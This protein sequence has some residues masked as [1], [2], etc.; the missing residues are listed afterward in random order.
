MGE[1]DGVSS[2][3]VMGDGSRED[4][5]Q[6]MADGSRGED[7]MQQMMPP[8]PQQTPPRPQNWALR[9]ATQFTRGISRTIIVRAESDRFVLVAQPGLRT[10]TTIP[11][12]D[13]VAS[14]ADQLVQAIWEF[15]EAWGIAGRDVHWRPILQVRVTP[16]GERRL[17]ELKFHLRNSGLVIEE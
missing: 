3:V 4:G 1:W 14:A 9:D 13:S 2:P 16:G 12:T 15:Q 7:T 6:Q 10:A 11:I 8:P 17:E 5:K